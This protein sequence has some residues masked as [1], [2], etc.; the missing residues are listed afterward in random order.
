[1]PRKKKPVEKKVIKQKPK[2]PRPLKGVKWSERREEK[3]SYKRKRKK[4]KEIEKELL[5]E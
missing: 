3:P 1:M 2:H 4:E 5:E